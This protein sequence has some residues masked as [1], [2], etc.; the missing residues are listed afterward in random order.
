MAHIKFYNAYVS[1]NGTDLSAHV[2]SLSLNHTAEELDDTTMGDTGKGRLA[3]LI[4]DTFEVTFKQDFAAGQV[5][6]TLWSLVGAAAFAVILK[7]NGSVTG[8][9]NPKFTGNAILT[10]Y[11]PMT[12]TVG[13]IAT[14]T[15]SFLVD[16][17]LTRATSD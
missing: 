8:V 11:V 17:V 5:D 14:A 13:S 2:E 10:N 3:G 6:A 9:T 12:G 1:I 7:P 15:A 16:G 4:D